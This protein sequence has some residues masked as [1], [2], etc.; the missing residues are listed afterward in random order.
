MCLFSLT[1]NEIL[2]D[3][4]LDQLVSDSSLP[5]GDIYCLPVSQI[6]TCTCAHTRHRYLASLGNFFF[7]LSPSLI[8]VFASYTVSRSALNFH[9]V[10][11][12]F[13]ASMEGNEEISNQRGYQLLRLANKYMNALESAGLFAFRFIFHFHWSTFFACLLVCEVRWWNLWGFLAARLVWLPDMFR[14]FTVENLDKVHR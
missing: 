11:R 12:I 7:T 8:P 9:D 13:I 2:V 3:I 10:M 5:Q 6:T 14:C 4:W 1:S